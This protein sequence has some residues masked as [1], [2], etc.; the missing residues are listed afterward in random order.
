MWRNKNSRAL[1]VGMKIAVATTENI[2][3]FL[4]KLKIEL[5]YNTIVACTQRK[6]KHE[7]KKV[8]A[9]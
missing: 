3:R 6:Q 2:R 1:L 9:L 4:K 8:Y 5:S 7:F